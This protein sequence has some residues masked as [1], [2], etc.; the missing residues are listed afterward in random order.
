LSDTKA[1]ETNK[2]ENRNLTMM[3]EVWS[4]SKRTKKISSQFEDESGER[5]SEF[6]HWIS[7]S[8]S[9]ARHSSSTKCAADNHKK[10]GIPIRWHFLIAGKCKNHDGSECSS[11]CLCFQIHHTWDLPS[12][13]NNV[14]RERIL[15]W[16]KSWN[17]HQ[18]K[19]LTRFEYFCLQLENCNK[20]M[21]RSMSIS[22]QQKW[23]ISLWWLQWIQKGFLKGIGSVDWSIGI[24]CLIGSEIDDSHM[25]GIAVKFEREKWKKQKFVILKIEASLDHK[26]CKTRFEISDLS[27]F[28]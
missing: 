7:P 13:P 8:Q 14:V 24:N 25:V 6:R 2:S 16:S 19:E 1:K 27:A 15:I 20:L 4:D 3:I 5:L 10:I 11:L 21:K 26:L 17:W 22:D 9:T 23:K 12:S 18:H 28:Q